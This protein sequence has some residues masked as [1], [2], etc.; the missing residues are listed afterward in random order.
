MED[1]WKFVK[2]AV[3]TG[4]AIEWIL[5]KLGLH[6]LAEWVDAV[7]TGVEGCLENA[8]GAEAFGFAPPGAYRCRIGLPTVFIGSGPVYV[9]GVEIIP[10][11][12][13]DLT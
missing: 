13:I 4:P 5:K 2:K 11:I 10:P 12:G 7:K 9:D 8:E 1:I 6:D 3:I